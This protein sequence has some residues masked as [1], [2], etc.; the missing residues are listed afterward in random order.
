MMND[1]CFLTAHYHDFDWTKYLISQINNYTDKA[2]I[3][4]FL[5]INQDRT[6]KS[7]EKIAKFDEKVKILEYPENQK[8]IVKQGHDHAYVLNLGIKEASGIYL[9]LFDSDCHPFS[10]AWL[11]NCAK[12]LRDYD[13]IAAV[14][15]YQS[16]KSRITLTHPCFLF[17]N[18]TKL[19]IS[20]SF[21]QGLFSDN[22][23]TGRLIGQQLEA[24]GL[25]VFYS[26]PQQ[27]FRSYWG[28]IYIDTIY[29]NQR[30]SYKFNKD[31]RLQNQIDW[32]QDFFKRIVIKKHRYDF[33]KLEYLYFL[34]KTKRLSIF[35]NYL[36]KLKKFR[37]KILRKLK[38]SHIF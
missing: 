11:E 28:F 3:R 15:Y 17:L 4:E 32:Q 10:N 36:I 16:R 24:A 25:K 12:I 35:R 9:C 31:S 8:Y 38:K 20:L 1:I 33:S 5:I 37:G 23:D 29:H 19:T 18:L 21:D 27:A 30:G 34:Y 22:V 14:D 7:R 2:L 6:V 26:I 13:A